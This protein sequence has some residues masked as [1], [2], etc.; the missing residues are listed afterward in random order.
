MLSQIRPGIP[1]ARA[2]R[3]GR[4]SVVSFVGGG[5]KTT[6]M[7]RL[8]AELCAAGLRVVTT[9]TTHIS[10]DQVHFSPASM[11]VQEIASLTAQL[12]A[13]GQC[14]VIGAPDGKGRVFGASSELIAALSA[15]SDVDAVLVEADGSRSRPFKAPGEHEPVVPETTTILVPIVGLNTIGQSLDEDHVHRSELAAALAQVPVGSIITAETVARVLS[16]PEGGAK[17][18]PAGARLVPL[19]NKADTEASIQTATEVAGKLIESPIVDTVAVCCMQ[20]ERPVL[21][22]WAPV[23]AIV[24]E[25]GQR[26]PFGSAKQIPPSE[27]STLVVRSVKA[28]LEAGLEPVI[29]LIGHDRESLEK[30]LAG[31]PVRFVLNSESAEGQ[32]TSLRKSLEALPSRTGAALCLFADQPPVSAAMIRTIVQAHRRTFAAACVPVEQQNGNSILF[33]KRLFCEL[34]ELQGDFDERT[35]LGKYAGSVVAVSSNSDALYYID[36]P[37]D[38]D[39]MK[40]EARSRKPE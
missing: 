2:L 24:L 37:E 39:R 38:C 11:D 8:A 36:A 26:V 34:K 3:V 15:R 29:I 40:P 31:L 20:R 10:K 14:L 32:G 23:A 6:S 35:L 28:A 13:H 16:H 7:F 22:A 27:S 30:A 21:E 18:C 9:T 17:H 25:A 4:R 1:L 33:D 5:G 12:D 19:L